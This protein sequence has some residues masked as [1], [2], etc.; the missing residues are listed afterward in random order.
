[1]LKRVEPYAWSC[2]GERTDK[3]QVKPYRGFEA[4]KVMGCEIC[5]NALTP[6]SGRPCKIRLVLDSKAPWVNQHSRWCR[7]PSAHYVYQEHEI[8][9]DAYALQRDNQLRAL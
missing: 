5:V 4:R 8:R 7:T 3:G 6:P 2:I 9:R 1:M